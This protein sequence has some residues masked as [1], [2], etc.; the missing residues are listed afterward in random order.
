MT[1]SDVEQM[2][3]D[4]KQVGCDEQSAAHNW[5][6]NLDILVV[7]GERDSILNFV[8]PLCFLDYE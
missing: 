4:T 2:K 8:I 6:L 3:K 5:S 1:D 7:N